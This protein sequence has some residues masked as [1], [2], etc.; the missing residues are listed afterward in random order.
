MRPESLPVDEVIANKLRDPE[1]YRKNSPS[2]VNARESGGMRS[3]VAAVKHTMAQ[4]STAAPYRAI[5]PAGF[6][7][8]TSVVPVDASRS[9]VACLSGDNLTTLFD[10]KGRLRRTPL[11][12]P[13]TNEIKM[14][15]VLIEN[16]RVARAGAGIMIMP[17]THQP[18]PVGRDGSIVLERL[19]AYIRHVEAGAW[20]TVDVAS[21]GEVPQSS[22][23]INSTEIEWDNAIAKAI[24]FEIPRVDRRAYADQDQLCAHIVA[25]IALGLARTADAVLLDAVKASNPQAFSIAAIAAQDLQIE[26]IRAIAGTNAA[27]VAVGVDGVLRAAGVP[28]QLTPDMSGTIV[29]AWDRCVVA[30]R[31]DI[32]INF[33]RIGT[34]GD[35]MVTAWASMLPL[36]AAPQN[37][38]EVA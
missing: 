26:D 35:M 25:G 33:L 1:H 8:P 10:A 36:I 16:S 9:V 32:S 28:A 2:D 6:Q 29:G 5:I 7:E 11:A 31:D 21:L 13:S 15:A 19:P 12:A 24:R 17:E 23:P 30:I 27:G 20:S 38:W 3:L 37:F 22:L 14:D 34:A 4:A 18:R